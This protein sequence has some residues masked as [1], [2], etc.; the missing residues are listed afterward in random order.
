[1]WGSAIPPDR[2]NRRNPWHEDDYLRDGREEVVTPDNQSEEDSSDREGLKRAG[3]WGERDA[4]KLDTRAAAE[5][6]E[7]LRGELA[8]LS[9]SRSRGA[10]S[11]RSNPLS[12]TV[13]RVSGR[14]SQ[15]HPRGSITR[16]EEG[17]GDAEDDEPGDIGAAAAPAEKED[18]FE[19]DEFMREGHF[20]KRKDGQS[21]KKVGVIYKNLTVKGVGSTASFARTLPDA[22]LG[23]F[24]P[25]L[26]KIVTGFVPALKLGRHKQMRTLIHDFSGVVKDGEMM[27]VL[28]RPGSGCST[29]LK[30]ISNNRESYAAVEGDVSY[31]GIPAGKQKKQ[32]RGEV[33]YNPEDDSHMAD[34]NVWQTLKFALTNKTK[35][36]EKHEIPII[37]EALLKVFG[38]SHTKYTK[39]GD[40]YVRG[41]SGGERKRVS[42]AETLATKSS[43]NC[44]DN[45]TRG[46]DASTALDYAKSLRI[47]T[48]ISNR[49]TLVTL[50]QAG[51]QIYEVMDKVMV[52]DAGRCIYQGPANEAKQYF[53]DL[54]FKCPERQTTADFLT[55]V[56]DPTER[57]FRPGFEDKAPKTSEE[58]E[59]AFRES[60]AYKKVLREISE[61]EA[62][63][64]A[65]GY[66]DAKEFEGAVR[67][68]KSKTVRKKS[69]YTVSFIRQ[70]IACT[71]R[72]FWLTWGDQTTLYT[73]F[74]IIISNGLIV[75]S[76]FYG[77]SLDTSGAFSRGGSGFFSI[78]FLGWL[79]LSELMKAVSGRNVVKRHEDYAFYRPSA[80]AIARV[81]QDF[82]LLLAQV[83]PF[84]IIMYFM[85]GLDVDV[86]KFFI[87]FLFIYTTTFCIT[88]LYRMFAALSPSIDDAVRFA[89]IA[90]NLLIIYTGYVIPKPQLLTDY[91]WFGWIYWINPVAYSFESVLA[92][93]FSD[94]VMECAPSQL[95]PQGPG[96]DPAYQGCSLTGAPPNSNT[97]PGSDYLQ[98]SFN[99]SRSNLWRNFGVVIAF[100]VLYLL[101]TV[102]A[103]ETVSFAAS[104]GGALVFAKNKRAKQAVKEEAP[105]DEEKIAAGESASS[106]HTAAHEEEE[107]LESISSSE[108]VFTWKD[109]EYTVPYQGGERKLLNKVNGYAKPGV[110]IALVGASGA[111]KS[112]LLN[113]LSQRQSTGVVSG[114]FLVDGKDLGKAFQ[115]G[116]GF[117][118]QMDLHDGTATIREALEF[119]A[120]LRQDKST[121]RK[122]KLDYVNKIID[123]L[124]L[125][126]I[127][128]ALVSSL[129]VEQKKRLTIG[130]ELAAKPS[131][132]LFLDEPTSGLDSNSAYSI[133]QFLKKLAQA[134]QAIVCTIH[135]P[136]SVLI[137]QFDM[138]LA[139]NPGGNTFYFGPVGENGRD[140]IK[141]FGDRGVQCPPSKNVA[142]FI[143]ETA[144]KPVKRK[145]GSKINWNE[146]WLNSDNNKQMLQEIDRVKT[147]RS[148]ISD[149]NQDGGA[150]ESEFAASVWEQ[151]TMLTKRT[152]IQYWRDPS[153][154]Y[155]KLFVAVIIGIFNGFTFWQLG[156]SIGD[157]QNR[158]FTAFLIILI[159][160]TIVNAV[161][162][163]FYQ[164]MALWQA[165]ELPSRIYGWVA[166]TTAQVVA[167]IPIAIVSSVLY[168]VLWYFPTGLPT[169]SSTS[170]YVFLMTML[171]FLFISSWGQWICAFAPSF[172][173]ISNV[174]PFFFVMFGLFNGVVRPYEMMPVFWRYWMYYVNPSTYWIGG[175]LSATLTGIPVQCQE[176]ETAIFD[177]PPGQSCSSY[178]GA[179]ASASP[180]YLLNPEATSGCQ[181]CPYSVGDDYLA[182]INVKASD[183]WRD[184]GIFL[185]FCIS[186]WAL[187]YFFVWSIRIKGWKFGFGMVGNGVGKAK[188]MLGG[189]K[190]GEG[191]A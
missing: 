91:I 116:T 39:V 174:L 69:P 80:V 146:E 57:Q 130:V 156:N 154:L 170:G 22:I 93:E 141:Y 44:W 14:Q 71:Q 164:N 122:E 38:I 165:R 184:F 36:N 37:L 15:S 17:T 189:K 144:A 186:N 151:T 34:L 104:G 152:F 16:A 150:E 99:Y 92:N 125:Q 98:V 176:S 28:G 35:K 120:I 126:D 40:E 96:I 31:G 163:K 81:V 30:A 24:G 65:S 8:S 55:A 95:V 21:A 105:A 59:R 185:A 43:V 3:T 112:T 42:I 142:E 56:T 119:S 51:E 63:L 113:T 147:E 188:K 46:L 183:K 74:F 177:A 100:S 41:V 47:M 19:L 135:Q 62:E 87:Y 143:L 23:T 89:G 27:L 111:G 179:F 64:E 90:L 9:N 127:Q 86:S 60:D 145:D 5:D 169:D 102:I 172:T 85:T 67:E 134:G 115:R 101:V 161:V 83:I 45:S 160:P 48:D 2:D 175:V 190:K 168:W 94:R 173:V 4:G 140:V 180:G 138:I 155:G 29:F 13:S 131:L 49:T 117:C 61:Y 10:Q 153:Y 1:M 76:L 75:G 181:Y 20:E 54:G 73:K 182:T 128:D 79:Q 109:V 129:G 50:Y 106:S 53:E 52:I 159:P 133:V 68:S 72:E 70:V 162:P 7:V 136:S 82:P 12:R 114:E 78:L 88:S 66:V 149:Q 110:M 123:L 107:A 11:Q 167:E 137:Q 118:E 84:S 187:V 191:K 103:T 158:M 139:L 18:D 58:L 108:S 132:L 178:A 26:Y 97:V 77:Q 32:F 148:K 171:F 33:N 124:E 157:L 166:F 121:P 25:D 6:L